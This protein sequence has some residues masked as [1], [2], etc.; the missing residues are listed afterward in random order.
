MLDNVIQF[1]MRDV[2]LLCVRDI[3]AVLF[4]ALTMVV[5]IKMGHKK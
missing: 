5:A 2:I 1:R 3:P 4:W